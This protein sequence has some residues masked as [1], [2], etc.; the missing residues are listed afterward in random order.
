M[1]AQIIGKAV[2]GALNI[3]GTEMSVK[4]QRETGRLNQRL[5][6]QQAE[7]QEQAMERETEIATEQA[8]RTKAA[9]YASYAKSGAMP[10]EGTPLLVMV[11]QSGEMQRDIL[12][13]RR[14][15]M[16]QAQGLRYQ[17]D[18]AWEQAKRAGYSTRIQGMMQ[19]ASSWSSMMGGGGSDKKEQGTVLNMNSMQGS[20]AYGSYRPQMNTIRSINQKNQF[21][22]NF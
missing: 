13:N 21:K 9:Q 12:E 6:Y 17:G 16:I 22:Y 7:L 10:T 4:Q 2:G 15:R 5:L 8:R 19:E 14:N 3:F 11:E 18:I 20:N 1:W